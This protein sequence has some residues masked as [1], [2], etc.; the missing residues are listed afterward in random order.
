V[1]KI[2]RLAMIRASF[3]R[4][5]DVTGVLPVSPV[6]I[7]EET[8]KLPH[9]RDVRW[10]K[11]VKTNDTELD[12]AEGI[13]SQLRFDSPTVPN[14]RETD[15]LL[16]QTEK[17]RL[18]KEICKEIVSVR[19][20]SNPVEMTEESGDIFP[21]NELEEFVPVYS[22]EHEEFSR[23]AIAFEMDCENLPLRLL[24]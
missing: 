11:S 17:R 21:S 24:A 18:A 13:A 12:G 22:R 19:L 2:S 8:E 16:S 7:K 3:N 14:E 6:E 15:I 20:F 4:L 10:R 1:N 9:N 5:V 23:A